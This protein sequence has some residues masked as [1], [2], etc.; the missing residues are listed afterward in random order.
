MK[1]AAELATS[2]IPPAITL[3]LVEM[4]MEGKMQVESKN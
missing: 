4:T 1:F 2:N 3:V